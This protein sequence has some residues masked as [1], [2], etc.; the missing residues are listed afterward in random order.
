MQTTIALSTGRIVWRF[1]HFLTRL[2]AAI[3]L[4]VAAGCIQTRYPMTVSSISSVSEHCCAVLELR[5]YT[6]YPGKRDVL[7]DLFDRELVEPQEALGM[8]VVG[9]FRDAHNPARFVWIRG[10]RDMPA[11]G[12]ALS[13]FYGGSVWQTHRNAANPTMLDASNVLLLRPISPD[14]G[15]ALEKHVRAQVGAVEQPASVVL[16]T[17]YYLNAPVDANFIRF[18]MQQVRPVMIDAAASPIAVF[19]TEAADNNFPRLPVRT[20]EHVLVWFSLLISAEQV[21]AHERR[22]LQSKVWNDKVLPELTK[23]LKSPSERLK[24]EPTARLMLR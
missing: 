18:F 10:F 20:G 8:R 17:I 11:R 23:H 2:F 7:I 13:A 21:E 6:L 12:I 16:A 4:P 9:Q 22:L 19:Q 14:S 3:V 5:Q 24:L 15:F 1:G